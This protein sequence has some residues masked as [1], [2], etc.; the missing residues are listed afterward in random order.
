MKTHKA[1]IC[2]ETSRWSPICNTLLWWRDCLSR[3]WGD[4]TCKKCLK[5]KPTPR[6]AKTGKN[7]K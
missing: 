2:G 6:G 4:V 1:K 5:L 3:N 7:K